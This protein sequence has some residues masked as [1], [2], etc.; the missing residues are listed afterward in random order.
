MPMRRLRPSWSVLA[1]RSTTTRPALENSRI[2]H[3][4]PDQLGTAE[5]A[6]KAEQQQGAIAQAHT[7]RRQLLEHALQVADHG[8]RFS[9]LR[10]ADRAADAGVGAAHE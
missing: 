6:G 2:A 8:R 1:R 7:G 4:E 10:G 5:G 9:L 3:L